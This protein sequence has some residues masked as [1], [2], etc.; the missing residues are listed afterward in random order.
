MGMKYDGYINLLTKAGTMKD[1][2]EAYIYQVDTPTPDQELARIYE[3]NGLFARIIDKPSELA[4]K[5]GFNYGIADPDIEDYVNAKL[6][7]LK[8]HST[9]I[10]AV[11]WSRLFGGAAILINADDGRDL[12]EPLDVDSV[13]R[14][15]GLVLFERP[16]IAPD[17]TSLY[18]Y[19][20]DVSQIEKCG[21][22]EYYMITPTYGGIQVRVHE[23]RLLIFKNGELPRTG[24]MSTDYMF[25]G[26]PEYNRIK[27]ELRNTV[28]SHGNGYR[29][30][31]RCVQSVYKMKNL[32]ASLST[33]TGENNVMKRMQLIDM[34]RSLLNTM[35]IDADG[36]DYSFQ[37][38][39]LNG[40][41]DII[42]ESCNMLSAVT[43]IP[44]TILFGRSPAGENSTGESD[45][46]NYYDYVGQIQN[47]N[48]VANLHRLVDIILA[49]GKNDGVFMGIPDHEITANP[50]W[51]MDDKEE[52]ELEQARAQ[53]ELTKAQATQIYVD[54]QVLD[55]QEV[56]KSLADTEIYHIEDI[57][58]EEDMTDDLALSMIL[59]NANS[60]SEQENPYNIIQPYNENSPVR[61]EENTVT[62]SCQYGVG[63]IVVRDGKILCGTRKDNGLICGPGGHI[64]EG[65]SPEEAATREAGEE[66]AI[67]PKN[68]HYLGMVD[69]DVNTIPAHVLLCTE[70]EGEP[71]CFN[72]EME[73]AQF[74]QMG[75]ISQR[76]LFA[77]FEESIRL[78]VECITGRRKPD[79]ADD[80]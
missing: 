22:P 30:L 57:L 78:L 49:V 54:L 16:E 50:L 2:S 69:G 59:E 7:K 8:F 46:T 18:T 80:K 77:P 34:A 70:Y 65:E 4:F 47:P 52:A 67:V 12:D 62:D 26:A 17:Y 51:N 56:R 27:R 9:G 71:V 75:D 14:I 19:I 74:L 39:Q 37:T 55:P 68:M 76:K 10:Q 61:R 79:N 42:D 23:S 24:A 41:K 25:F 44:Q 29:L 15:D 58:S 64:E 21:K 13:Q 35:F 3:S 36:E 6:T 5:N 1:S 48:I 20:T 43:N 60:N 28:T 53:A 31:E 73:N 45:L 72:S 38:F 40:V 32:S 66:F 33:Q 11:K 63:V